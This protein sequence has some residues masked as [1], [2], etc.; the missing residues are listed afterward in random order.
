VSAR[1]LVLGVALIALP[2]AAQV[3]VMEPGDPGLAPRGVRTVQTVSPEAS[4]GELYNQVLLLQDEVMKLNGAVEELSEQLRQLKQQRLDDY[5]GLDNRI[6][7]LGGA[8]VPAPAGGTASAPPP[9]PS[10]A[11][12]AQQGLPPPAPAAEAIRAD[13]AP[14]A[15]ASVPDRPLAGEQ[16]AYQAAFEQIRSR[17]FPQAK[18]AFS[19][20]LEQYPAGALTGNAH[21]WLGELL[22][23]DG[24]SEAA[25]PHYES[26]V[27]QFPGSTKLPDGLFKLGRIYHQEGDA[28]RG[29]ELLQRVIDEYGNS[30]S[31]APRLAREYIQQN[32]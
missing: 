14:R 29:R 2:V 21:F 12:P 1:L 30:D 7:A 10:L 4:R 32:F 25:K 20:F 22:L 19:T 26:L 24:D 16:Q 6:T 11:A 23:L 31:S 17:Q 9:D 15:P 13:V 27:Y 18:A 8:A 28:Q 5:I 3:E